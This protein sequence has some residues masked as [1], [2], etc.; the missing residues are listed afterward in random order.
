M[1][2]SR[3]A[4]CGKK[5]GCI[6]LSILAIFIMGLLVALLFTW[7]SSD[8]VAMPYGMISANAPPYGRF[9]LNVTEE[10]IGL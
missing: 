1:C 9:M 2:C 7:L 8:A 4:I 3:E 10:P 6:V 5:T